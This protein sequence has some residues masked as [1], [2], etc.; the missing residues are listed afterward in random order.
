MVLCFAATFLC[1]LTVKVTFLR[2]I[3]EVHFKYNELVPCFKLKELKLR[4]R[5]DITVYNLKHTCSCHLSL[6]D[7]L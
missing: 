3:I 5:E 1:V 2:F 7:T 4:G 6:T